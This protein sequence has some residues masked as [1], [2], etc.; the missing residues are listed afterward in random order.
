MVKPV[1]TGSKHIKNVYKLKKQQPTT[2]KEEPKKKVVKKENTITTQPVVKQSKPKK[3][4]K[5]RHIREESSKDLGVYL[6]GTN[7]SIQSQENN[8]QTSEDRF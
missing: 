6:D 4:R 5:R 3:I 1:K 2:I 8:G 7:F